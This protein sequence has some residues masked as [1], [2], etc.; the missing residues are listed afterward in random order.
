MIAEVVRGFGKARGPIW[1]FRQTIEDFKASIEE[2]QKLKPII[3]T[4]REQ[5]ALLDE[6]IDAAQKQLVELQRHSA[7]ERTDEADGSAAAAAQPADAAPTNGRAA[8]AA[9]D[10]ENWLRLRE[11]WRAHVNRLEAMIDDIDDGRRARA[12]RNMTRYDYKPI[13]ARL[14]ADGYL[15]DAAAKASTELMTIF[16][17]YRPRN[18]AIPDKVVGEMIVLDKLLAGAAKWPSDRDGEGGL[19][20]ASQRIA[21]SPPAPPPTNPVETTPAAH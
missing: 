16:A 5:M 21:P 10:Q 7:S 17:A 11:I 14:H 20:P 12:Y 4:L 15:S 9:T 1:D 8:P 3:G 13:I 19:Q 18:R 6:K 2:L